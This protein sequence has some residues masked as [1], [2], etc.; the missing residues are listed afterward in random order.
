MFIDSVST[1]N[2]FQT[3]IQMEE[4][5]SSR[6]PNIRNRNLE[7]TSWFFTPDTAVSHIYAY[8]RAKM[9]SFI[10]LIRRKNTEFENESNV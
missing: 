3:V 4:N 1:G 9:L 2:T 5:D 6:L 8:D 10:S 7:P